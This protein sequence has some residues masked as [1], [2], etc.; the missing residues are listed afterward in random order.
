MAVEQNHASKPLG[1]SQTPSSSAAWKN[2]AKASWSCREAEA[3][4]TTGSSVRKKLNRLV[5]LLSRWAT[6]SRARAA[7]TMPDT[8]SA[9]SYSFW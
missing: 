3:K 6:P 7:E 5:T 4:S 9:M 8:R 2:R 1:G